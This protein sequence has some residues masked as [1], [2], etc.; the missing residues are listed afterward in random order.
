[1]AILNIGRHAPWGSLRTTF[2]RRPVRGQDFGVRMAT[3]QTVRS[4]KDA[5]MFK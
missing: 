2:C 5:V 4:G 3:D 1:M